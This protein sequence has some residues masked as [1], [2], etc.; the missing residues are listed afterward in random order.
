MPTIFSHP[1]AVLGLRPWLAVERRVAIAGAIASIL[2]D[3]DAIGFAMGV[4]YG[5]TFGH[6]GF[7]HSLTFALLVAAIVTPLLRPRR[8]VAA[9]A[10]L[11]VCTAS[12]GL[13]DAMTSGGLGV[14]FFSPIVKTRYF[15]PWRPIRVS[16]IGP[17]SIARLLPVLWSEV[18]WVW[19]PMIAL[20]V[21]GRAAG[22]LSRGRRV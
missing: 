22:F 9:F 20:A 14:A 11:F 16:P 8:F 5:S 18:C 2:P 12:H 17:A 15:L 4:P 19:L 21:I 1:A 3:G 10:F 13:L 7:T 6:R